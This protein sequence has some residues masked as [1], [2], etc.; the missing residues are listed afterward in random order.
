MFNIGPEELLLILVL[1]LIFLGPK[2]LPDMAR[3][4][5]KGLREFRNISSNA[6]QE[7]MDTVNEVSSTFD[8][9]PSENGSPNGKVENGQVEGK[10]AKSKAKGKDVEPVVSPD[11][12]DPPTA[13]PASE[14]GEPAATAPDEVPAGE[15]AALPA[16]GDASGPP[17]IDG[18]VSGAATDGGVA[19]EAAIVGPADTGSTETD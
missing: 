1:A 15:P 18:Q 16:A 10:K 5:G 2:K 13:L 17:A 11:P 14:G 9:A 3:Q 12:A 7:L 4:I 8:E 6:R 19:S